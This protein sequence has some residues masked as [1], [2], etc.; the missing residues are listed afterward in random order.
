MPPTQEY[1]PKINRNNKTPSTTTLETETER[2][3]GPERIGRA[4]ERDGPIDGPADGPDG[5]ANGTGRRTGRT[6]GR[7]TGRTGHGGGEV[8]P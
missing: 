4:G 5:L 1:G 2:A 6:T 7:R 8:S 3:D